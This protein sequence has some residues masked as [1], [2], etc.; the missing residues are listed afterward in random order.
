VAPFTNP[1]LRHGREAACDKVAHQ[2]GTPPPYHFHGLKPKPSPFSPALW[3][4]V[5]LQV[6]AGMNDFEQ[7]HPSFGGVLC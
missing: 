2:A 3:V 7:S 5:L 6:L 4:H 1:R